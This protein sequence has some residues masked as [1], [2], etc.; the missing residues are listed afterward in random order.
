MLAIIS[1][2]HGNLAA[3]EAVLSDIQSRR[4]ERII[5]LGD[6]VGY[7]PDPVECLVAARSFDLVLLGNHEEAVLTG[8]VDFNS[9]A[10]MAV[11]WTRQ[12][13]KNDAE[14]KEHMKFLRKLLTRCEEGNLSFVHGSPRDPTREY[15]YPG[16]ARDTERMSEIFALIKHFCFV[17]HTHTPGVFTSEGE[18]VHPTALPAGVCVFHKDKA[19]INVGSV[20]QPRDDDPRACYVTFDGDSAV[21]RR[22]KY[23]IKKTVKKIYETAELADSLGSRLLFGK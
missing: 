4:V 2:V 11:N 12:H 20:G 18:Y 13:L 8:A 1:D 23:D 14:A 9:R 17:G 22:V 3:L 19:L 10:E 21:F 5:C 16:H 15:I 6:L 7:G